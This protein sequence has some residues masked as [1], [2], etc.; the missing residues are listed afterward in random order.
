MLPLGVNRVQSEIWL[1]FLTVL[2]VA[3]PERLEALSGHAGSQ[4]DTPSWVPRAI[5]SSLGSK[6]E[7]EN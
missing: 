3:W 1:D 2:E 4:V 7:K 6:W 5:R